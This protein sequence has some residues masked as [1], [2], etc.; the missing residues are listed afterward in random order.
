MISLTISQARDAIAKPAKAISIVFLQV[1]TSC[2]VEP[3]KSWYAQ[4]I[5]NIT[6]IVQANPIKKFVAP[7][8]AFGISSRWI[9]QFLSFLESIHPRIPESAKV[10]TVDICAMRK[11]SI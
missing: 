9:S 6:A 8:I 3:S 10:W 5:T 1:V 7:T 4:M 11:K 2:F